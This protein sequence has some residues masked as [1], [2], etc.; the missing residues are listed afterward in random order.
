MKRVKHINLVDPK[1]IDE[2][3]RQVLS[4]HKKRRK[5]WF[6]LSEGNRTIRQNIEDHAARWSQATGRHVTYEQAKRQLFKAIRQT[7]ERE[8]LQEIIAHDENKTTEQNIAQYNKWVALR[9]VNKDWK[10][11]GYR[12]FWI[13]DGGGKNAGRSRQRPLFHRRFTGF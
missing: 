9:I 10:P 11:D 3:T 7:Q 5:L 4:N 12:E 2:A 6:R 13:N 8:Q 1:I